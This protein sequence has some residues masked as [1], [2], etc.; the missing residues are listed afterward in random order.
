MSQSLGS[1]RKATR[2][3]SSGPLRGSPISLNNRNINRK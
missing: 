2:D 1:T 3:S